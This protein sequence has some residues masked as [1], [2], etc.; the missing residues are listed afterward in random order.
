[1]RLQKY[2]ADCGICSRREAE[3]LIKSGRIRI[4]GRLADLG[5]S[6]SEA[7]LVYFDDKLIR[8]NAD[9][10]VIMLNKP[11][12]VVSTAS[13]QFGRKTVLD[14]LDNDLK[15]KRLYPVGRLDYNTSGLILLTNN[16]DLTYK[17]THPSN[18]IE[19]TY[20][21]KT[22]KVITDNEIQAFKKG[23][24]IDNYKTREVILKKAGNSCKIVLKEGRNRQV[25]KMFEAVG[26]KVLELRRVKIGNLE[27]GSLK[28]GEY[29]QLSKKEV[30]A[31]V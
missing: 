19:K 14:L 5:E 9:T 11:T 22:N 24:I 3:E 30:D 17:L 18:N 15:R 21:A 4:N 13:D 1:M 16:G 12:G 20:I 29:R 2:I 6:V 8:K 28:E 27:L 7:D 25:R 31:L 23:I 26:F 10:I